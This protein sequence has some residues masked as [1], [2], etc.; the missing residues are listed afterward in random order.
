M[1]KKLAPNISAVW[2]WNFSA[3]PPSD[4]VHGPTQVVIADGDAGVAALPVASVDKLGGLV[5]GL[6]EAQQL[7]NRA[8]NQT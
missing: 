7:V 1:D 2:Q 6:G 3:R 8:K 4:T 5:S